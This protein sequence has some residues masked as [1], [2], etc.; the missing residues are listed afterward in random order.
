MT[1]LID[2]GVFFA[3]YSLRDKHHLDSIALIV[4]LVEGKWGRA[5]ITNHILDET[6]NILKYRLSPDTSR[7]FLE[8]FI[9]N[10]V[11]KVIYPDEE[12]ELIALNIFRENISRKGFSYTD[13]MT[14]AV[15]RSLKIGYLLSYDVRSFSGLVD[16]VI[17]M[18]Y[19]NSLPRHEQLKILELL[20]R[21][22]KTYK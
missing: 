20:K 15:I 19:W 7:A 9:D 4:H 12:L 1:V 5:Y 17:G 18:N 10:G 16:N 3:Y 22:N 13:A 8:T 11:I 21:S 6:L 14:V 2:T